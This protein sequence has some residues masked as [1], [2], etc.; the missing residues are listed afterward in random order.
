MPDGWEVAHALDPR[1]N[2]ANN[3]PDN[4]GLTNLQ[5]YQLGTDPN[6][7]DTDGDGMPDGWEVAHGLNPL[8]PNDANLDTDGDGFTNLREYRL[9]TDPLDPAS[10]PDFPPSL[11]GWWKLDEGV[12]TNTVDSAGYGND[13]IVTSASWVSGVVSNA[14]QFTT[15]AT[16]S[17]PY[18]SVHDLT[19]AIT[20]TILI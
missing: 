17:I 15:N 12:G 20:L 13:G 7:A 8:D 5:E 2:D 19:N 18:S 14:L 9:G 3:D 10:R 1:V 4:D 6:N 16:V 11:I